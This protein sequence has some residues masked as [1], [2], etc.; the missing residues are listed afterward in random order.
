MSW[1]FGMNRDKIAITSGYRKTGSEV[2]GCAFDWHR[3]AR[4]RVALDLP[5]AHLVNVFSARRF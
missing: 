4:C 2:T 1:R 5:L 3:A